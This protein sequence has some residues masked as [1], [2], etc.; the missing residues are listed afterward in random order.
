MRLT[1]VRNATLLVE[2]SGRRLLVDPALDDAGARPPIENT[3]DQRPNPLVPLPLPAE[4]RVR[5]LDAVLVTH[6]HRDDFDET[7]LRMVPR[8]VPVSCQPVQAEQLRALT[9]AHAAPPVT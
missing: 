3:A 4:E 6:L 9:P 2:L 1:L 8:D 5:D 7:A